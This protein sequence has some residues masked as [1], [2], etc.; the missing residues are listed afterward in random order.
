MKMKKVLSTALLFLLLLIVTLSGAMAEKDVLITVAGDCTIGGEGFNRK[1]E[2][3]FF[4]FAEKYGYDYFFANFRD[5]FDNDDITFVNLEGVLSDSGF[6]ENKGKTYRFRGD[7]DFV[8]ILTGSSVEAVSI[9]N[10]HIVDFGEQGERNTRKTLDESGVKWCRSDKYFVFEKDGIKI[11]F[12]G[13]ENS[14]IYT[15]RP[16]LG[17]MWQKMKESGEVQAIVIYVH[18]GSEYVGEHREQTTKIVTNLIEMGADLVVMSHPHVVQGTEVINNRLVFYS[19]G[20]FVFGGNSAIRYE[21]Y[22]GNKEVTSLY[23]MVVQVKM[24][25]SNEGQFLGQRAVIY[26]AYISDDPQ[27]NHFQPKRLSLEEAEPVRAAI[28]RDTAFTLP[29]LK[30]DEN[31]FAYMELPYTAATDGAMVPEE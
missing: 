10:N 1:K 8:K 27:I 26:P 11:G 17:K 21:K 13:L 5:L 29:E 7:T 16:A 20:N 18:T 30:E 2:D 23:S 22:G 19:L 25:F 28:Q 6:L 3:S 24:S 9:A 4:T 31:G 14:K 15:F 12:F